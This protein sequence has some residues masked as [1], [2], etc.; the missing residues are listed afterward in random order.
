MQNLFVKPYT[1]GA[2]DTLY[3]EIYLAK[4]VVVDTDILFTETL[5][6]ELLQIV[7][8]YGCGLQLVVSEFVVECIEILLFEQM[9]YTLTSSTAEI[10]LPRPLLFGYHDRLVKFEP[11]VRTLYFRQKNSLDL[12]KI[13]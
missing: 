7:R 6:I 3:D 5:Q 9:V 4:T 8:R 13:A 11:T 2:V 1:C 12:R 10:E